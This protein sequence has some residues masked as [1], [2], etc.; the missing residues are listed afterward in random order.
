MQIQCIL[1]VIILFEKYLKKNSKDI[2]KDKCF[3]FDSADIYCLFLKDYLKIVLKHVFV[4]NFKSIR[5]QFKILS[6]SKRLIVF[7]MSLKLN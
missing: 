6:Q 2:N 4:F 3:K 5:N 7:S 1:K